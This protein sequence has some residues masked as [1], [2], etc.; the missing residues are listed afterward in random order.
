M[1]Q[2]TGLSLLGQ[3]G[4][5]NAPGWDRGKQSMASTVEGPASG[6]S[7]WQLPG[8]HCGRPRAKTRMSGTIP[9]AASGILRDWILPSGK[10]PGEGGSRP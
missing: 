3:R 1:I 6:A 2:S 9:A 10:L 5:E 4:V 7:W 8:P